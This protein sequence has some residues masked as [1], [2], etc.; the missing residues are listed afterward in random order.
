MIIRKFIPKHSK[1]TFFWRETFLSSSL[2][3]VSHKN[4]LEKRGPVDH[5]VRGDMIQGHLRMK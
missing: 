4:G 2:I 1:K 5:K 3:D